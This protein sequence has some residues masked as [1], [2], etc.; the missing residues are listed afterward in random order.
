MNTHKLK[1]TFLVL[2]IVATL[3]SAKIVGL[4][5]INVW[6]KTFIHYVE[7][8]GWWGIVLYVLVFG[9]SLLLALPAM[10]L[11]IGAG[12][13]FQFW[14]GLAISLLGLALGAT[15]GFLT[16]RYLAR[17]FVADKLKYSPKFK[18]ID[19]A[20]GN[21]G[22][23]I[24]ALLRMCPLPFGL[25]NYIFG[26]TSI[27]FWH[28]LL[29]T[30]IGVLPGCALFV[31]LG[32]AGKAGLDSASTKNPALLLPLGIGLIAGMFCLIFVGKIARRAVA[33]ATKEA[34]LPA[35][36]LIEVDPE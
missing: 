11:S 36:L 30:V 31:Y 14:W 5:T 16:S 34:P 32:N 21:E 4:E 27:P 23:K 28:Y 26:I 8:L 15:L 1:L 18:A 17:D 19:T 24:V 3:V 25:S 35:P 9:L 2:I 22:W 20:V 13:I 10:P 33:K 6:L 7:G 29:A 12:I